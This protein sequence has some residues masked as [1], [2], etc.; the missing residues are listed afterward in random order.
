[1]GIKNFHIFPFLYT[2][3][4]FV[5]SDSENEGPSNMRSRKQFSLNLEGE[6]AGL[7]KKRAPI[8][9]ALMK[10]GVGSWEVHT[11]GIGA[12]ILLQV[13]TFFVFTIVNIP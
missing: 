5:F 9:P 7:R 13:R 6:I 1:M 2:Y 8:N 4:F 3:L 10:T 11:R 12:K